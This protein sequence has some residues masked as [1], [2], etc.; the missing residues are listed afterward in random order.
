MKRKK[1]IKMDQRFK[2]QQR[3]NQPKAFCLSGDT[4]FIIVE[5][6]TQSLF[7]S[8]CCKAE[9]SSKLRVLMRADIQFEFF[10]SI[11]YNMFNSLDSLV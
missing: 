1:W 8:A 11:K 7:H 4:H 9:K 2:Q 3:W 6:L 10:H 5:I